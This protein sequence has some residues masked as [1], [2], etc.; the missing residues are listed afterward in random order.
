M[1]SDVT[2]YKMPLEEGFEV[3]VNA[4]CKQMANPADGSPPKKLVSTFVFGTDLVLVFE[5]AE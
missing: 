1:P 2:M 3:K 5:L 4:F